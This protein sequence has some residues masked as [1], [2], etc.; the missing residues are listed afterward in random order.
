[1]DKKTEEG[2]KSNQM[3]LVALHILADVML[4]F[5]T[6]SNNTQQYAQI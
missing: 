3:L 5:L 6:A 1:M 2:I 4:V